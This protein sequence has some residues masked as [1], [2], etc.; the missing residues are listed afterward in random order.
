[1]SRLVRQRCLDPHPYMRSLLSRY[2]R[3]LVALCS[4]VSLSSLQKELSSS[5]RARCEAQHLE[6][7]RSILAMNAASPVECFELWHGLILLFTER[8]VQEGRGIQGWAIEVETNAYQSKWETRSF[9][10]RSHV[11]SLSH[12]AIP[13]HRDPRPSIEITRPR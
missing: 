12:T 4:V 13:E 5:P 10:A 6:N 11:R 7:P 2:M 8:I 3:S 1:M 9:I